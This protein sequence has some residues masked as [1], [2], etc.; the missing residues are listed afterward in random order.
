MILRYEN[1]VEDLIA[2]QLFTLDRMPMVK[3]TLAGVRWGSAVIVFVA[4]LAACT[5]LYG[6]PMLWLTVPVAL[7]SAAV[8]AAIYPGVNRRVMIKRLRKMYA[9]GNYQALFCQHE[10]EVAEDGLVERTD[11][12]ETKIAWAGIDRIE[13]TPDVTFIY[14]SAT[15]AHVV[16]HNRIIEGDYR[17]FLTSLAQHYHP[18]GKLSRR[19]R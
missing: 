18:E 6:T 4:I 19:P 7:I 15:A 13:S 11:F 10:L 12:N 9:E 17:A 8:A 2:F 14:T 3:R 5:L 1:T 16:P